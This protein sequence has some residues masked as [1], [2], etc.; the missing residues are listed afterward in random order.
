MESES[1]DLLQCAESSRRS[2]R[3]WREPLKSLVPVDEACMYVE[4]GKRIQAKPRL[5]TVAGCFGN[6]CVCFRTLVSRPA[7]EVEP[8]QEA[9]LAPRGAYAAVRQRAHHHPEGL[10]SA[11]NGFAGARRSADVDGSTRRCVELGPGV[12]HGAAGTPTT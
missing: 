6:L 2:P 4:R 1:D 12:R 11:A 8:Q 10:G 3:E 7:Q 9:I 5:G